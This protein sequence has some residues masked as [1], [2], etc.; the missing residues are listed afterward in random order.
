MKEEIIEELNS[1]YCAGKI[2]A[3]QDIM[4]TA[5]LKRLLQIFKQEIIKKLPEEQ[6]LEDKYTPEEKEIAIK[7]GID[8]E[9]TPEFLQ[10]RRYGHNSCLD[11]IKKLI[12][13]IE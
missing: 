2:N 7:I 6:E 5:T 10:E 11:E 13:S 3:K 1:L 12:E 8:V 9:K 4:V